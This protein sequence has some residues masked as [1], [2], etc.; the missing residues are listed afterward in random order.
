MRYVTLFS[1][2]VV[3]LPTAP[4]SDFVVLQQCGD[5]RLCVASVCVA[6]SRFCEFV[7]HPTSYK[8]NS[9]RSECVSV[10]VNCAYRCRKIYAFTPHY[11]Y[12]MATRIA[13]ATGLSLIGKHAVEQEQAMK[14][15]A[16]VC[17]CV[18]YHI[19]L[20]SHSACARKLSVHLAP[21]APPLLVRVDSKVHA[22]AC[23]AVHCDR[24]HLRKL[25]IIARKYARR[26]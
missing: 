2:L 25:Y 6:S 11:I 7:Q 1:P 24:Q 13:R 19:I 21:R 5:L 16:H 3:L 17:E 22:C 14:K 18:V 12:Y 8:V 15:S 10:L 26:P 4:G 23:A 9:I 20:D